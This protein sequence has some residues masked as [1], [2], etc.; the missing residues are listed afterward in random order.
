[1]ESRMKGKKTL[2]WAH[3]GAGKYA[4]ENTLP[5]FQKAIEMGADGIELDVQMTKDNQCVVIH[6]ETI[7]RVSNGNAQVKDSTLEEL[8]EFDFG[9][10]FT[11]YGKVQIPTL[12]E[13]LQLVVPSGLTINIEL[14]TGKI[15]YKNIVDEVLRLVYQYGYQEKVI[16]SSFNHYTLQEIRK[17]D[18]HIQTGP[19]YRDGIVNVCEYAYREIGTNALHPALYNTRYKEFYQQ[20]EKFCQKIH[21]W[22]VDKEADIR[23]MCRNQVDAIITNDPKSAKKIVDEYENGSLI[24]E[25]VKKMKKL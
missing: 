7:K 3:R 5:A 11:E 17:K 12:E 15:C 18:K 22:T 20:A 9:K 16:L 8:R 23:E 13:V 6:D 21:V 19:L 1:M 10:G 14:K 25:L 24:P 4:P 2:V